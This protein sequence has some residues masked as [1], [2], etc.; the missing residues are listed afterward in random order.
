MV[1]KAKFALIF[2][3]KQKTWKKFYNGSVP[4]DWPRLAK[5]KKPL[6]ALHCLHCALQLGVIC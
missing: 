1:Q 4:V 2:M 6:T 3:M 5:I